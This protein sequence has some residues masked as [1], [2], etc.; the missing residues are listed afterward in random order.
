MR[1]GAEPS[2]RVSPA[3]APSVAA[4]RAQLG[5]RQI[6]LASIASF[7][8][9]VVVLLAL[10]QIARVVATSRAKARG[11][12]LEIGHATL[13]LGSIRFRDVTMRLG[14]IPRCEATL[15]AVDVK[16]GM[17]PLVRR[18]EVHGGRV[19]LEGSYREL[20]RKLEEL[21]G[22]R[23]G[24]TG[25]ASAR[26]SI[27]VDGIDVTWRSPFGEQRGGSESAGPDAARIWGASYGRVSGEG[28]RVGA[29]LARVDASGGRLEVR[30]GAAD[31]AREDGRR[32]VTAV[33]TDGLLAA[34][35]ADVFLSFLRA[36]KADAM[37]AKSSSTPEPNRQAR[38]KEQGRTIARTVAEML[39]AS[40]PVTLSGA[41]FVVRREN[42]A[43][44]VGP[45]SLVLRKDASAVRISVTSSADRGSTPLAVDAAL[46]LA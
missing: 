31:F 30:R 4:R 23:E 40:N 22:H 46:P 42:Q 35:D 37:A 15:Y 6:V 38:L 27:L 7:S 45:A 3:E 10:P 13:G 5:R 11:V 12:D 34:V 16:P 32:V 14:G 39:P 41:H 44:N 1:P 17:S 28:E 19:R 2:V 9:A 26:S 21:G 8:A 18:V 43:L 36:P 25:Q 29:D 20:A 33:H 24:E